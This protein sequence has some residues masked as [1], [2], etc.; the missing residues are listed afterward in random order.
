MR[1]SVEDQFVRTVNIQYLMIFQC[2]T[3]NDQG[4]YRNVMNAMKT[5]GFAFKHAETLWKIVAA[6]LLLV[7]YNISFN[8]SHWPNLNQ[9]LFV[10]NNF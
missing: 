1:T 4:D 5:L 10:V 8:F 7:G 2:P 9:I 3:I 6:V